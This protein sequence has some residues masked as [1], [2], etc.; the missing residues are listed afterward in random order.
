MTMS[1]SPSATPRSLR[2][3]VCAWLTLF[4][5]AACSP[6]ASPRRVCIDGDPQCG[7]ACNS[8]HPCPTGLYC[9][10]DQLCQKACTAAQGCSPNQHCNDD[11]QCVAGAE[12][13]EVPSDGAAGTTPGP[14]SGSGSTSDFVID[15]GMNRDTSTTGDTCQTAD[16]AAT[17]VIPN[18]VLVIDQSSSMTD[19]FDGMGPRWQVLRDFLLKPDGLIAMFETR[20]RFGLAM[21]SALEEPD[22]AGRPQCPLV[23]SVAPKLM[24]YQDIRAAY[25]GAEPIG[26][27]PTGDAID[28]IVDSLPKPELDKTDGPTV[29]ILATDG[30]PDRCEELNPQR[31]QAEAVAAVERAFA[32]GIRTFIISVGDDVSEQHQQD[33]ANAGVGHAPNDPAQ[34]WRAGDDESLRAALTEIIGA[35]VSCEVTLQGS[36]QNGDPCLGTVE[37]NSQKLACNSA[38]GW[39]LSDPKH[40]RLLGQ[41]CA[42][43]KTLSNA[44]LHARF[45]CAVEVVF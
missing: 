5:F 14:L 30:E 24:N 11:G 28:Q 40:I 16:V 45:P 7:G 36:V 1:A 35:Q 42:D 37:L 2:R 23:T 21:Y 43:W 13:P 25:S 19:N 32:M 20:V 17:R 39:E 18:V 15:A 26:E 33:V 27:T 3:V 22:D 31:G 8:S 9:G 6:S 29:L 38:D 44:A 34:Y 4:S 10:A 12:T 41:A